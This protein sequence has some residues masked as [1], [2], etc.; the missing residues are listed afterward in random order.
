[1]GTNNYRRSSLFL[2]AASSVGLLVF[3]LPLLLSPLRWARRLRWRVPE[4]TDLTVYLG[5]SL[6]AVA[7]ALSVG[8]LLAARDPRRHRIVFPMTALAGLAADRGARLGGHPEEAALDGDGGDPVLGSDGCRRRSHL[9]ARG[10]GVAPEHRPALFVPLQMR[11]PPRTRPAGR[12][13]TGLR[14]SPAPP[15]RG[16][17]WWRA[18]PPAPGPGGRGRGSAPPGPRPIAPDA[19]GRPSGRRLSPQADDGVHDGAGAQGVLQAEGGPAF[20]AGADDGDA[21]PARGGRLGRRRGRR[22]RRSAERPPA[23]AAPLRHGP[24]PWCRCWCRG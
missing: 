16:R 20:V 18:G 8:G 2:L 13:T 23:P 15:G 6:G 7:T 21:Q 11:A 19:P 17:G 9:P 4:D 3:A 10:R 12:R 24:G 1:M 14:P 5:R 22:P